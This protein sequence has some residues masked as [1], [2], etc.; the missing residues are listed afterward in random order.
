VHYAAASQQEYEVPF[1]GSM[2]STKG[3]AWDTTVN[4]LQVASGDDFY[5]V[6]LA[7]AGDSVDRDYM[8]PMAGE[9][10]TDGSATYAKVKGRDTTLLQ[11]APG[12]NFYAVPLARAGGSVDQDYMVPMAGETCADGAPTYAIPMTEPHGAAG[13]AFQRTLRDGVWTPGSCVW[14]GLGFCRLTNQ[15]R[16]D[17]LRRWRSLVTATWLVWTPREQGDCSMSAH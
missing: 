2:A 3:K 16:D 13:A 17:I 4:N 1:A 10:C 14:E 6:P 8:V 12:N 15:H 5:A 7:R 9:S 11:M